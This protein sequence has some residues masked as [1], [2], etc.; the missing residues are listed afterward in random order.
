MELA[1]LFCRQA[2]LRAER[3]FEDLWENTDSIEVRA[4]K[5]VLAGRYTF[6][7]EG[8]VTPPADGDWVTHWEPGPS[9]VED[10][11]RRIPRD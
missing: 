7:E 2:R 5:R 3:L 11:R 10:V 1:D 9:T 6:L 4:A 8:V